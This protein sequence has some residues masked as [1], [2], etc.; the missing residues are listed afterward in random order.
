[1]M[2]SDIGLGGIRAVLP[3]YLEL[4]SRFELALE[5]PIADEHRDEEI[6]RVETA[7]A[8]VRIDPD[9]EMEDGTEYDVSLSFTRIDEQ[10]QRVIGTF[11]L[12]RLLYDPDAE[13]I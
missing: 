13:L 12:Q 8:V 5:L 1:M 11:M 4:F 6:Q 3:R 9:E 2:A 10:A 7:V